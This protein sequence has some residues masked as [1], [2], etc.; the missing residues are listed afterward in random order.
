MIG[1][2]DS[3]ANKIDTVSLLHLKASKFISPTAAAVPDLTM[4]ALS[5]LGGSVLEE[6][7][8]LP[9]EA[10]IA[11]LTCTLNCCHQ[12]LWLFLKPRV[13]RSGQELYLSS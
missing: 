13:Q 2:K 3:V 5:K 7:A 1:S 12:F 4:T 10:Q 11:Q 9:Q 6:K 8:N